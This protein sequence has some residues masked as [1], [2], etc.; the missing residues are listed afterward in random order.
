MVKTDKKLW[1]D[2]QLEKFRNDPDFI[3]ESHLLALTESL[4]EMNKQTKLFKFKL[5]IIEKITG[6][7]IKP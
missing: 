1:L 4:C 6:S 2:Y 5:W 3:T 7:L